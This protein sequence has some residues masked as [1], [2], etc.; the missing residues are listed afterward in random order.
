MAGRSALPWLAL[1][2]LG[3][4]SACASN[5]IFDN[6]ARRANA[7][8]FA[9]PALVTATTR[10]SFS[11]SMY[12][13]DPACG[14]GTFAVSNVTLPLSVASGGTSPV[15]L[16]VLLYAAGP[17]GVPVLPL[18]KVQFVSVA[19]SST[20]AY[21]VVTLPE[22]QVGPVTAASTGFAFVVETLDDVLLYSTNASQGGP[23]A[24]ASSTLALPGVSLVSEDSG[25]T[26]ATQVGR[27]CRLD[28][29]P[30]PALQVPHCSCSIRRGASNC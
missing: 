11:F 7:I 9:S 25:L 29:S 10:V 16:V 8:D 20:P 19:V 28:Q 30:V 6:T 24:N 1:F 14:V 4:S 22:W 3:L 26:W 18:L 5:T 15:L 13:S 2:L 17:S 21:A 12:S 27:G 23:A